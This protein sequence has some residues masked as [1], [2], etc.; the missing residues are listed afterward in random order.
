M[1]MTRT[2]QRALALVLF[3]GI[4]LPQAVAARHNDELS[5]RSLGSEPVDELQLPILFGVTLDDLTEN[6]GDPR[7]GGARTHEGLDIMAPEGTPIVTPTK[8][9][10]TSVG[11]DSSA[12]KFVY[13]ANPGG[14]TFRYMHLDEIANLRR[15]D[16][17]APGDFI[18][19]VGDTGNAQGVGHHLHLEIRDGREATDPFPRLVEMFTFKEQIS[20]LDNV[21]D[22]VDDEGDYA[23]RLVELYPNELRRALNEGYEL[24]RVLQNELKRQKITST[25][26]LQEQLNKLIDSIPRMFT[27]TIRE[28]DSGVEVALLQIYLQYRAP[29]TAGQRLKASGATGYFGP[30]TREALTAYQAAKKLTPTGEFDAETRDMASRYN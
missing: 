28:G 11:T 4:V 10:V 26:S 15:G 12:G 2:A 29:G 22:N 16:K 27:R 30:T 17:L 3:V 8:A 6:F 20:F 9:I 7:D 19:T 14:E 1:N 5:T 21:F 25:A 24:P 18:G 23:E 13:T